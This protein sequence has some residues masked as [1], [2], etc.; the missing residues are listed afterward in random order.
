MSEKGG[1]REQAWESKSKSIPGTMGESMGWPASS[2]GSLMGE[3]EA[4]RG[5]RVMASR[6]AVTPSQATNCNW[7]WGGA[8]RGAGEAEAT[9]F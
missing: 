2:I 5:E 7:P 8:V 1:T 9:R 6:E 4:S 3:S